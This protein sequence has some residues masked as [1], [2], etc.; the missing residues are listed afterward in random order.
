[1]R[2]LVRLC[3]RSRSLKCL[4]T[5]RPPW[6]MTCWLVGWFVCWLADYNYHGRSKSIIVEGKNEIKKKKKERN[7]RNFSLMKIYISMW[8]CF[9][10]CYF[11][12]WLPLN[13]CFTSTSWFLRATITIS[14]ITVIKMDFLLVP[15]M[16]HLGASG[17][18]VVI[19]I[20]LSIFLQ[21]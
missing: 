7:N 4:R 1:M 18:T 13:P 9:T 10:N 21:K 12:L 19:P 14:A 2:W 15:T 11:A 3:W 8:V 17:A 6:T 16:V 20:S 5:F